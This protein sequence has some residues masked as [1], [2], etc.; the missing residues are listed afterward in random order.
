MT[1]FKDEISETISSMQ[2]QEMYQLFKLWEF[3]HLIAILLRTNVAWM[4]SDKLKMETC[5]SINCAWTDSLPKVQLN[6]NSMEIIISY[7]V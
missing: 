7:N 1:R 4:L 2:S 3:A 6:F 5:C